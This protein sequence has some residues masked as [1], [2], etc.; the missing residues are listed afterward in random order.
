MVSEEYLR[1]QR[2]ITACEKEMTK[3]QEEIDKYTEKEL[4]IIEEIKNF[5]EMRLVFTDIVE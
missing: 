5:E 4:E 1:W 3:Y 2:S